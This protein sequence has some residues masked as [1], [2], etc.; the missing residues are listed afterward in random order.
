M[1]HNERRSSSSHEFLYG[2]TT[3]VLYG[4]TSVIV[5][6]PLDT[7][8]TKMQAQLGYSSGG[9]IVNLKNVWRNE[10]LIGFYRG[11]WPPLLGSGLYR[12]IQFAVFEGIYTATY[13]H[14]QLMQ[15]IPG[16]GG[17]RYNVVLAAL[18]AS[19]SRAIIECPIEL[20][21]VKRQTNQ[22]WAVKELYKGFPLQLIRTGGVMTTYF[23]CIDTIRRKAPATFDSVLGQFLASSCSATLGFWL[24][25]P[26]EVL[27]NQV[28]ADMKI[29][30][31][32]TSST[33]QKISLKERV[34]II[35]KQQGVLGLYRG[36]LPGTIR[37]MLSNG[38]SMVVMIYAQKKITQWGWR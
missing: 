22:S 14:P 37:S 2:L 9:M 38:V 26:F 27:K 33:S 19:T 36:I 12:S 7:L 1:S 21:K 20:A 11:C 34:A 15:S 30:N 32:D 18:L 5:G 8:K 3:G 6:Q 13:M 28:Q 16:T 23:I 25:W 24:V 10:G 35:L 31:P 17:L 4:A 29:N